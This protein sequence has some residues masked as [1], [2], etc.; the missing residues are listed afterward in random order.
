MIYFQG[1]IQASSEWNLHK[2]ATESAVVKVSV[3]E[4]L[5]LFL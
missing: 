1:T 5:I 2:Q 4:H 3:F